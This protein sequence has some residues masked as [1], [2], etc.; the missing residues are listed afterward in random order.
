MR[1]FFILGSLAT[2]LSA[3]SYLLG[4]TLELRQDKGAFGQSTTFT[5]KAGGKET[6]CFS[7]GI[8]LKCSCGLGEFLASHEKIFV[9]T[10]KA[11][12]VFKNHNRTETSLDYLNSVV[13]Y[14]VTLEYCI[15]LLKKEVVIKSLD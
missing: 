1:Y 11:L 14:S 3:E 12:C 15:D 8:V 9:Q 5:F 2:S 4:S 10:Y 6:E 7:E 13:E